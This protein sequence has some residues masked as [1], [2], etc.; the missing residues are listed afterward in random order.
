MI[1]GDGGDA[2]RRWY[3]AQS[4]PQK[5]LFA[6]ENLERIGF[7][8]FVP[9]I[10]RT[11][12]HARRVR[13][14]LRPLFPRYLF[15]SLDLARDRWRSARGAYGVA[16]LIMEGER[17][18]PVPRGI[19]EALASAADGRGGFDFSR[20]LVRGEEVRFLSGPFADKIGRLVDMDETGRVAVLLEI[21]G[22]VRVVSA[23]A[24][25]L[26]PARD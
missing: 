16:T 17:P 13:R 1:A 22:A 21:M 6:A 8:T 9:R 12:R 23:A 4:Q 14:V 24:D 10:A 11:V 7:E 25:T 20:R 19:V 3:V 5:E 15:F 26:L 2:G 18:K